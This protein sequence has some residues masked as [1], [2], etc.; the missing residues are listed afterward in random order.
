MYKK[1]E[2][3]QKTL[4]LNI[5]NINIHGLQTVNDVRVENMIS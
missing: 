5:E 1:N 3:L 2:T 4:Y